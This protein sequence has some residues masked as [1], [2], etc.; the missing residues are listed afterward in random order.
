MTIVQCCAHNPQFLSILVFAVKVLV[1]II[2]CH[3]SL[4]VLVLI[5]VQ[6]SANNPQFFA[7]LFAE[8]LKRASQPETNKKKTVGDCQ[9]FQHL[10]HFSTKLHIFPTLVTFL[11]KNCKIVLRLGDPVVTVQ[12]VDGPA[13]ENS[14]RMQS[15]LHPLRQAQRIE[16]ATGL[17]HLN[18]IS[19]LNAMSNAS[20]VQLFTRELS[21]RQLR[22]SGMLETIRIRRAGYPI[23]WDIWDVW[24]IRQDIWDA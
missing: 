4:K 1:P 12:E 14:R 17:H 11:K 16:E 18:C 13:D 24:D 19:L 2:I 20:N 21:C 8:D 6:C 9:D 7:A 5:I 23:R 3:N 22:Y 10:S 15:L